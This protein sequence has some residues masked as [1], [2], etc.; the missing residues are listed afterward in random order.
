MYDTLT[1]PSILEQTAFGI[2]L[3]QNFV[4]LSRVFKAEIPYLVANHTMGI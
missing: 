3:F 4:K 1:D 2:Y